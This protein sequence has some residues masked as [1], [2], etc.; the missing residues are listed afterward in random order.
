MFYFTYLIKLIYV[1]NK[2]NLVFAYSAQKLF[3]TDWKLSLIIILQC[4]VHFY[5]FNAC[6]L[7]DEYD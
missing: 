3:F 7:Y 5:I 2:I 4:Y 1:L 6:N